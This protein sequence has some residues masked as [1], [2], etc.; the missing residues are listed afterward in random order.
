[1][2][3]RLHHAGVNHT[4]SE[5][6]KKVWIPQ[7]RVVIRS[8]LKKC[9][10][11]RRWDGGPFKYPR[12]APLPEFRISEG[13][14]FTSVGID[15]FGP[16]YVKESDTQGNKIIK[17]VWVCLFTCAVTRAIHLELVMD[18]TAS[19]FIAAFCRFV[20][21]RGTPTLIISDNAKTFKK[22]KQVLDR[23]FAGVLEC[24]EVQT[25]ISTQGIKWKFI[26]ELAPWFGGFY[27]RLVASVKSALKKTLGKTSASA[28]QIRTLLVQVEGV[29]NSH[30]LLRVGLDREDTVITPANFFGN[31]NLGLPHISLNEDPDF[32]IKQD[33]TT[34]LIESWQSTQKLL[35]RFWN[36]WRNEYLLSL[37][38][39]FH[40]YNTKNTASVSPAINQMVL[41]KDGS[42][43]RAQWKIGVIEK[44]LSPENQGEVRA[45]TLRL[46]NGSH[47]N[48]STKMLY[49]LEFESVDAGSAVNLC[50]RCRST[51]AGS[52]HSSPVGSQP[53]P[54]EAT[55]TL[56]RNPPRQAAAKAKEE[57]KMQL[58]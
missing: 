16:L 45:V 41:V 19:E 9:L 29:L 1:M 10:V 32:T 21:R 49:P 14:P 55:T 8:I 40:S 23:V 58:R 35:E 51:S 24:P 53:S 25:F 3:C 7:A 34:R 31:A 4:L 26:I 47:I 15:Y 2:H 42:L 11:C 12:L 30:R 39:W 50:G 22:A 46:P 56:R 43:S 54:D 17:K 38:Q 6:R 36:S 18:M 5:L 44:I 13:P 48:R 57:M 27:E 37:R 52:A 33:T 28:D 20:G